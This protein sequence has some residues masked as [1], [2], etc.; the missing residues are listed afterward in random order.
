[1]TI[2]TK[3]FDDI[4]ADDI[5]NLCTEGVYENQLLEF[6]R[7][8]S[9]KSGK[10]SDPWMTGGNVSDHARDHLFREIVAFANTAYS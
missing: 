10:G 6:K 2:L 3:R 4:D 9:V 1:M 8:L 5:R 7:E